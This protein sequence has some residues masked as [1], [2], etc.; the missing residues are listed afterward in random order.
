MTFSFITFFYCNAMD[1]HFKGEV[2]EIFNVNE[3]N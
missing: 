3:K 1:N 2:L